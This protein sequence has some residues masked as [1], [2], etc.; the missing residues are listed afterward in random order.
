VFRFIGGIWIFGIACGLSV[1]SVVPIGDAHAAAKLTTLYS[2]KGKSDGE[3]PEAGLTDDGSG[4]L[5]STTF[6]ELAGGEVP[7]KK[8]SKT[9]GN[10]YD[11]VNHAPTSLYSFT[12]STGSGSFP[13]GELAVQNGTIYGTTEYG[14]G[15]AC[16]GLGCGTAFSLTSAGEAENFFQFCGMDFPN[17]ASGA[18]PR[19]GPIVDS[20]GNMYGTTT[21]GGTGSGNLC[22]N[23][24]SGCGVVYMLTPQPPTFAE[25]VLYNFCSQA[26]CAD[27]AV[28][29]GRLLRDSSGN[30]YGT[31]E[32]GGVYSE[33]TIFELQLL[34]GS[35]AYHVIYSFCQSNLTNCPDGSLPEAGLYEDSGGNLYG[36]TTYGGGMLC[37]DSPGCGVVFKLAPPQQGQTLWTETVLHAF[38]GSAGNN[39]GA[40]PQAPVLT[41]NAGN[42]YGTTLRGGAADNTDCNDTFGCGTVFSI[43][44]GGSEQI[45]YSFGQLR[46]SRDGSRPEGALLL[47]T[48]KYL[49]GVTRLGGSTNCKCGTI[50][51]LK[52][53]GPAATARLR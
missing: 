34:N 42:V 40:F 37:D 48:S 4:T 21:L 24:F 51:K 17:C 38:T 16:G 41:D 11:F 31:T 18:L 26:Q 9:C 14:S 39:D 3:Y 28:P 44:S 19:S 27:G 32:F 12:N 23:N 15:T 47:Q 36:T 30:L 13:T 1:A 22:G 10:V 20:A 45:V 33:G 35:Y 52:L 25:T 53:E 49:Y 2:F 50:F 8:C 46:G 7:G 43:S 5:Y 29:Y 6:G